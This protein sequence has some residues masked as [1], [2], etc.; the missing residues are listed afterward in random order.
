MHLSS[1]LLIR[2]CNDTGH[3]PLSRPST[4]R[5]RSASS[6]DTP[7]ARAVRGRGN[8]DGA[9]RPPQLCTPTV[10]TVH[11]DR[12]YSTDARPLCV[13]GP[14]WVPEIL[15]P[16]VTCEFSWIRP[17][18]RSRRSTRILVTSAG[19]CARPPG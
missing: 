6:H 2:G 13:R 9:H 5:L 17:P 1:G 19:G 10:V 16:Y 7:L 11:T 8:A 12:P 18:S 4:S 15:S 14:L 3:R